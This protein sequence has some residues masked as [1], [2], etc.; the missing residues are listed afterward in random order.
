MNDNRVR[1]SNGGDPWI[2]KSRQVSGTCEKMSWFI[3][4]LGLLNVL[5]G[6]SVS[7]FGDV[8]SEKLRK[9]EKEEREKGGNYGR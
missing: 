4:L 1:K 5:L 7:I 3:C 9:I 8:R 6:L 2:R